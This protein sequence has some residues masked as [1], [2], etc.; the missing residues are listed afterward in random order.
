M[1]SQPEFRAKL[2]LIIV[3]CSHAF[4]RER[5]HLPLFPKVARCLS[6]EPSITT[7]FPRVS[8]S[9]VLAHPN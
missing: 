6:N 5:R 7:K 1:V 2:E 4:S 8:C 9:S 3:A